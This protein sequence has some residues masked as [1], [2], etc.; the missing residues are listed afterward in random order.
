MKPKTNKQKRKGLTKPPSK[1]RPKQ[2]PH[3]I[4][5]PNGRGAL[6]SGGQ[7]GNKG[8][9]RSPSE[10]REALRGRLDAKGLAAL[11]RVLD[12]A[13]ASNADRLRA[14][15]IMLRH[16]VGVSDEL[17]TTEKKPGAELLA[18]VRRE[19]VAELARLGPE[20]FAAAL[21][22]EIEASADG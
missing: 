20:A 3:L 18:L 22:A 8:G 7:L 10:L 17:A 14:V 13:A 21:V 1:Q 2:R 6:L 19:L 11:D 15:E 9:G 4:P 12:D 16:G 5:R